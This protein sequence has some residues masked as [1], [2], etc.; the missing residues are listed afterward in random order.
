MLDIVWILISAFLVL[1]MQAGFTC[2]E[3]G[4]VRAKNSINV[5][6]KNVVDFCLSG[7]MFWVVG[8]AI[9]FGPSVAG[10]FGMESFFFSG[11]T[12][13]LLAFF[14]FQLVFCGTATTIVSGSVAERMRFA[15][16]LVVAFVLSVFIYPV[17]GH[18]MWG[19]ASQGIATGWLNSRGFLDFAGSTVV[20]STGGWVALAAILVIGPRLGRF[21]ADK[22]PIHGHNLPLAALGLFLLWVGWFGFNGGS[23]LAANDQVPLI[24]LNTTLAACAGG[25][26]ALGLTWWLYG[27]PVVPMVM[28]GVLAGLVAITASAPFM[29]LTNAVLVGGLGACFAV[30]AS[31][32]L[33]RWHIDDVIGAVPVHG[34]AGAW[35]TIALALFGD[36]TLWGTGLG[37]WEQLGIQVL[38]VG[39]CFVWAFGLGFGFLWVINRWLP[40]RVTAEEERLGLNMV[41]HG[42]STALLDL[43]SDMD[44]HRVT[45]DF[46]HS[47]AAEPHTE[48][49]QIANQYNRVVDSIKAT[50][51]ELRDNESRMRSIVETAVE[52]II[53]IDDKG[54]I[55]FFNPA[56]QR[57]FGYEAGE[58]IGRNVS[59]LMSSPDREDH[60]AHLKRYQQ[61]G[62]QHIIGMSREVVGRRKDGSNFPLELAVSEVRLE[63]RK[64]FT[65]MLRDITHRKQIEAELIKTRDEAVEASRVKSEFLATMSH[66]I[67]TPM[68]GV[69]GMAGLLLETNL[70]PEQRECAET[71]RSSGDSLLTI[72]NDI[73]DFSKVEAGKLELETLDFDLRTTVEEALDLLAEKAQSKGLELIGLVYAD[74]PADVRGDPGRIRQTLLNIVNNAIK[75]TEQGEVVVQVTKS[76]ESHDEVLVRFDITDTGIGIPLEAQSRLFQSFMQVDGSTSR[77]YGGTGLG[78][79][80]CKQLTRLMGGEIGVSSTPGGG[81]QF[82]F[83]LRLLKQPSAARKTVASRK[84]LEGLHACLVADNV[85]NQHLLRHYTGMWGVRAEAVDNGPEAIQSLRAACKRGDGFDI[86]IMDLDIPGMDCAELAKQIRAESS[87]SSIKLVLLTHLGRRGEAKMAHEA[88]FAAYLTKPIHHAQLHQALCLVMGQHQEEQSSERSALT[89]LVTRHTFQETQARARVKLLLAEDNLV[90][91]KVAV[92]MLDK[93]GYRVDVVGNGREAIE[94]LQR[95]PYDVLL[96]DCQMPEMDGFEATQEI[97]RRETSLVAGGPPNVNEE[98]RTTRH[99]RRLPIIAMTANAMKGDRE[100]CFAKGMDDFVAKPVKIEELEAV[101]V[102]WVPKQET[103][104]VAE[105]SSLANNEHPATSDEPQATSHEPQAA[106]KEPH[107]TTHEPPLD[108]DTLNGL[109]KL[110]DG[111]PSF[112]IEVIQQF[113]EDGPRHVAAIRQAAIDANADALMKAAHG[114][115]GSCRNM[116]ALPLGELCFALEQKGRDGEAE[117]VEDSLVALESEYARAQTALEAEL[118]ALPV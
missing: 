98:P 72:I 42:A 66:E 103:S 84:D 52:G 49:G 63:N 27:R 12:P 24:V 54:C 77:K 14:L 71:V 45:G 22:G 80:I 89:P 15:G 44:Y 2:L 88:G 18:W 102:R 93:L 109:K 60:D 29:S 106:N 94:A 64:V 78:L 32:V 33:E 43:F 11:T 90:N 69:L 118:A 91:Q 25:L 26:V 37:R 36:P 5:A 1:L 68:N 3:T 81:S 57:I 107:I 55:E 4:L 115:K 56:A 79:A 74:V 75:F 31:R 112:L 61:T 28:N 46:S 67:R 92:R 10:L 85:I 62:Q 101:L 82:W 9:M 100:K 65:G 116:G 113:L 23:T 99:E 40:L 19:G 41:E 96:M 114:F 59:M 34:V 39:S 87:F 8:F 95:I 47:V 38:G 70:T 105:D 7:I 73:L 111:D 17:I 117:N 20:H 13:W 97:R 53:T 6:L 50:Q 83:T 48:V 21:D 108:A 104:L 51:S 86:V 58:V 35:G 16:Y 76:E 110:G 30:W